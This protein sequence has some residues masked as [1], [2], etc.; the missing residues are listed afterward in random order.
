MSRSLPAAPKGRKTLD[1]HEKQGGRQ[2]VSALAVLTREF[3]YDRHWAKWPTF[4]KP[5]CMTR[6]DNLLAPS[7][8]GPRLM[9]V[10]FRELCRQIRA[11]LRAHGG[12]RVGAFYQ[13]LLP[14][15]RGTHNI[16]HA[17]KCNTAYTKAIKQVNLT[18]DQVVDVNVSLTQESNG[19]EE[20]VVVGYGSMK[21]ALLSSAQTTITAEQIDKT[22]N[23]TVE[24]AIQGRSAGVFVTQNSGQPGG[25]MS[26]NIRGVNS[27]NGSN[28][29]LYVIDGV[30]S[31]PGLPS[32]GPTSSVN[33][34]AG[35]NPT[36]IETI[37]I[38][39]GPSATAI[40]REHCR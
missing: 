8:D 33:P 24:Q 17:R 37:D 40:Y 4:T 2:S 5:N 30:Q 35:L 27:I 14:P 32:Y 13:Q 12:I 9:P 26:I 31:Q 3:L 1:P 28:E 11:D 39:Q 21:K 10:T 29:P 15:E 36:D 38:L 16:I 18:K 20:V 22:V 23:T 34:L 7:T 6:S 19:L 25:A